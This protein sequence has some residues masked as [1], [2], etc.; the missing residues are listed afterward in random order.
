MQRGQR[1]DGDECEDRTIISPVN[2]SCSVEVP[3][4]ALYNPRVRVGAVSA[5]RLRAKAVKRGQRAAGGDCKDRATIIGPASRC[6]PVEVPVGALYN[7]PVRVGPVNAV[8]LL[9]LIHISEPTR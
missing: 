1:A 6:C 5:V 2:A 4:G 7:A 3:I 9:S 8:R